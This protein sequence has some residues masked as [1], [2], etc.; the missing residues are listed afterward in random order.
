MIS[1]RSVQEA[2]EAGAGEIQFFWSALKLPSGRCGG[3]SVERLWIAVIY[4]GAGES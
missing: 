2:V 1:S 4:V 3:G